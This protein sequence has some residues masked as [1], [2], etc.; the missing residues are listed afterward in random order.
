MIRPL[1]APPLTV[2]RFFAPGRMN[3]IGE[4]VDYCDGFVLPAAIQLGC[5]V[6]AELSGRDALWVTLPDD[7]ARL[8]ITGFQRSRGWRNY[9]GG[10]A[11]VLADDLGLTAPPGA[12]L[13]IVGTVPQ[14]A[15]LSSSA[16]LEVSVGLALWSLWHAAGVAAAPDPLRLAQLAQRAENNVVDNPCGIM[17]QY[18]SVFGAAG[19]A[20]MLDCRALTHEAVALPDGAA[21]I[22]I[23][24]T[25]PHE[26]AA[27][28][29]YAGVR[30]D[31]GDALEQLG[32]AS[33]RDIGGVDQLAGLE[34]RL[35]RRARHV[36][37]EIARTKAAR[38]AIEAGDLAALG[39]LMT[40]GHA[41]LREDLGTSLPLVDDLQA[42]M[43]AHPSVYGARMMGGGFGGNV[44]GVVDGGG[45]AAIADEL[46]RAWHA[47]LHTDDLPFHIVCTASAGAR[48]L[49]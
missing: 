11:Q 19:Q 33:W 6:T 38:L 2:R 36:V 35:A 3:I 20:L 43:T 1:E 12:K 29:D 8:D 27:T 15:G 18:A 42:L 14:G 40:A 26:L 23:D 30:E 32:A 44:I 45:A 9:V 28:A 34:G 37:S 22:L 41:S 10:M 17:D 13:S 31:I 25:V 49:D 47:Q 5:T 24:S 4:H 48:E 16:A 46:A 39:A 7:S 21:F